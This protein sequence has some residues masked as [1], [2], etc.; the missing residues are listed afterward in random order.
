MRNIIALFFLS[1]TAAFAQPGQMSLAEKDSIANANIDRIL[2][3]GSIESFLPPLRLLIDSAIAN[4]PEIEFAESY[5]RAREYDIDLAKKDWWSTI[6][7]GGQVNYGTFG[8]Q[9]LDEVALGQQVNINVLMPLSTL[10]WDVQKE[11]ER[12]RPS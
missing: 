2:K 3:S 6:R 10:G 12:R 7:L 5:I 9:V 4:S 11:L 1:L 8:N